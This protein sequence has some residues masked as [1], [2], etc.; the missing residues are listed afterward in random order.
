LDL[1]TGGTVEVSQK[2]LEQLCQIEAANLRDQAALA[3]WPE[4]S[5]YWNKL[6]L[7]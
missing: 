2:I 4:L 5:A 7:D 6:K 1:T 3:Q